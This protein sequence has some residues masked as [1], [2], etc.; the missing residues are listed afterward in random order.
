MSK[1]FT[2]ESDDA[3]PEARPRAPIVPPGARKYLTAGGA[4]RLRGELERL[5]H[6]DR[7]AA[8]GDPAAIAA[9]DDRIRDLGAQLDGAEVVEPARDDGAVHFGATVTVQDGDGA[10]HVYTIVGIPEADPR[11]GR[12]SYLA[13]VAR[14][15][16][17]ARV[18]DAV[19]MPGRGEVEIVAIG[20]ESRSGS[21]SVS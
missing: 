9:I 8:A 21:P 17:G 18:G 13:P 7:P 15:L 16:L 2:R 4:A 5:V 12:V 6:V 10:D 14:A 11:H 3:P 1:A 19:V 20:Y